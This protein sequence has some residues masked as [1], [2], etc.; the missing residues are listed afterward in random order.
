MR[1]AVAGSMWRKFAAACGSC[2]PGLMLWM[3]AAS[4]DQV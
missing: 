3:A 4:G 2:P 1:D